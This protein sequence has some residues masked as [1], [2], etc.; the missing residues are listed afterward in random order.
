MRKV[1]A[2][3]HLAC[4]GPFVLFLQIATELEMCKP[5]S[6]RRMGRKYEYVKLCKKGTDTLIYIF[7]DVLFLLCFR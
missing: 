3:K 1:L 4:L 2:D 6:K 5:G 7:G